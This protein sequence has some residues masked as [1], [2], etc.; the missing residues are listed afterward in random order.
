M[1]SHNPNP[2]DMAITW[3]AAELKTHLSLLHSLE[4]SSK[5]VQLNI[6]FNESAKNEQA[7]FLPSDHHV[8]ALP[9]CIYNG[10]EG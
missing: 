2:N 9:I 7:Y 10:G 8:H 6:D 4:W 1:V 5:D 3:Q